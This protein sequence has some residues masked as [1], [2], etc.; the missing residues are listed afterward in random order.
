MK[1][2]AVLLLLTFVV[3]GVAF[4]KPILR[5]QAVPYAFE[6]FKF[7]SE[8]KGSNTKYG[9]GANVSVSFPIKNS[10]WC[11]GMEADARS[12]QIAD[13]N[14]L[15]E[16]A[17]YGQLT[18]RKSLT[19]KENVFFT[20]FEFGVSYDSFSESGFQ[21]VLPSV[22]AKIGLDS[23]LDNNTRINISVDA[24]ASRLTYDESRIRLFKTSAAIGFTYNY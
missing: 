19:G 7:S 11:Y 5:V 4:A 22:G 2:I 18:Y 9:F 1:K 16:L 13:D 8:A 10:N 17:F 3:L 20:D 23:A 6:N 21:A 12:Y 14:N 15:K 24:V